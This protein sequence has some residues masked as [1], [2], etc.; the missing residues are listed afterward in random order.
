[1]QDVD[2]KLHQPKLQLES[3][4]HRPT[5]SPAATTASGTWSGKSGTRREPRTL[6]RR[7]NFE[8]ET[9]LNVFNQPPGTVRV[10]C[11]VLRRGQRLWKGCCDLRLGPSVEKLELW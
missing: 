8:S 7:Y 9:V 5:A 11:T 4:G 10:E 6:W 1:M 3:A 2:Q